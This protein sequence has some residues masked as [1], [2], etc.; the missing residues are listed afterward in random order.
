MG[1]RREGTPLA[2][3]G[4]VETPNLR[5]AKRSFSWVGPSVAGAVVLLLA[6]LILRELFVHSH[7]T[8]HAATTPA[9]NADPLAAAAPPARVTDP[10]AHVTP[11]ARAAPAEV[12]PSRPAAAAEAPAA[13]KIIAGVAEDPRAF[14]PTSSFA[15]P[16]ISTERFI[17]D[18]LPPFNSTELKRSRT[19]HAE[20]E[21]DALHGPKMEE[22]APSGGVHEAATAKD[23]NGTELGTWY[24]IDSGPLAPA[25][26]TQ[27][28]QALRVMSRAYVEANKDQFPPEVMTLLGGRK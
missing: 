13:A 3:V 5:P 22:L 17:F 9:E 19:N 24:V 25:F 11:V 20:W 1:D 14:G 8:L 28:L 27:S 23:A 12:S 2:R 18:A 7:G 21:L 16:A 10:T 4:G 15:P 26:A 6:V